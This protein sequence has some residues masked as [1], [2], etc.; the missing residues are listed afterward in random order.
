MGFR[1]FVYSTRGLYL[2]AAQVLVL[3]LKH[4]TGSGVSLP[5]YLALLAGD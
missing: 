5:F 1:R 4:W 3:S 2:L